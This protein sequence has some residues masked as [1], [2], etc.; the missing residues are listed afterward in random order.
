MGKLIIVMAEKGHFLGQIPQPLPQGQQEGLS[1]RTTERPCFLIPYMQS[2]SEM[3]ASFDCGLTSIHSLPLR[4]TGQ[5]RLHSCLHFWYHGQRLFHPHLV[6]FL[7]G[8]RH[9]RG[10][11]LSV[12]TMAIRV[13][14]SDI[15]Q[16]LLLAPRSTEERV[17][18]CLGAGVEKENE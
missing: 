10:L 9:T 2:D 13:S 16:R 1:K 7:E 3:K 4:T 12:L 17:W 5:E 14:L 15:L 18:G 6:K 8:E 11:H